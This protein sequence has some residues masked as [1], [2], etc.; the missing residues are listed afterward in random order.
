MGPRQTSG[1]CKPHLGCLERDPGSSSPIPPH[2]ADRQ[3]GGADSI[4]AFDRVVHGLTAVVEATYPPH[5]LV[6]LA[7]RPTRVA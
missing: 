4:D 3:A 1:I 5:Y 7:W 6:L 2:A